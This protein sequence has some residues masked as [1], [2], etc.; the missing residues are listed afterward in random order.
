MTVIEKKHSDRREHLLEKVAQTLQQGQL[1]KWRFLRFL[2]PQ[3]G[4]ELNKMS[5]NSY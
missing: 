5:T 3:L 2:K 4:L 1:I